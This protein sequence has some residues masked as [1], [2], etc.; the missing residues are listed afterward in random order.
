MKVDELFRLTNEALTEAWWQAKVAELDAAQLK[1][2]A[3]KTDDEPQ[4]TIAWM[5]AKAE[6]E[7]VRLV[8][9][10]RL[11]GREEPLGIAKDD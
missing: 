5:R 2:D 6:T 9:S 8:I 7:K 4:T 11:T 3:K 10:Y 1:I